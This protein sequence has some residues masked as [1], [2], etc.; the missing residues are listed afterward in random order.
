[1]ELDAPTNLALVAAA[2]DRPL[3]EVKDLN[4]AVLH[5]VAPAGYPLHIPKDTRNLVEEA[6]QIVPANHRDSWR[7]HRVESGDTFATIAKKYSTTPLLVASTNGDELPEVGRL[8]AVPS[9]YPGDRSVQKMV[10]QKTVV[11]KPL[12]QKTVV[13][14]A[15]APRAIAPTPVAAHASAAKV[16]PVPVR[17]PQAQV[18]VPLTHTPVAAKRPVASNKPMLRAAAHRPGA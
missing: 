16:A 15:A 7:I 1:M 6:F 11:Q 5:S 3:S 12:V 2:L 10:V 4:P 8:A 18:H 17:K 14:K 9:P 13:Q